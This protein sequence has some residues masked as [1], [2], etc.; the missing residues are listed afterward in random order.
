[1]LQI[2]VSP[3]LKLRVMWSNHLTDTQANQNTKV[4]VSNLSMMNLG[5]LRMSA[6]CSTNKVFSY[7]NDFGCLTNSNP[8]FILQKIRFLQ[9]LMLQNSTQSPPQEYTLDR[10]PPI[11]CFDICM[12]CIEDQEFC[13]LSNP[14]NEKM[15][16]CEHLFK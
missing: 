3:N 13:R 8:L 11:S 10:K 6:V 2:Q 1:M 15:Y 16:L 9:T 14:C 4:F 12:T 7:M 5:K